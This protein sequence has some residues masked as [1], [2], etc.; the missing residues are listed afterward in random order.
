MEEFKK[1]VDIWDTFIFFYNPWHKPIRSRLVQQCLPWTFGPSSKLQ[2]RKLCIYKN[3]G[4]FS[5]G[6]FL[7]HIGKARHRK[8]KS[9]KATMLLGCEWVWPIGSLKTQ[10][11]NWTEPF[12]FHLVWRFNHW[13]VRFEAFFGSEVEPNWTR[14]RSM[15]RPIEPANPIWFLKSLV[16]STI[17]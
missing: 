13:F 2:G 5:I 12:R 10:I 17:F 3:V 4:C 15:V 7:S 8:S 9:I 11:L 1:I 16:F 14:V 6:L